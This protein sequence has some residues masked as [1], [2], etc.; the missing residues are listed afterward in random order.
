MPPSATS[1]E[2]QLAEV[3]AFCWVGDGTYEA[4]DWDEAI[5]EAAAASANGSGTIDELLDMPM[6]ASVLEAGLGGV[7]S[8]LRRRRRPQLVSAERIAPERFPRA[9]QRNGEAPVPLI[10]TGRGRNPF[11]DRPAPC[12]RPMAAPCSGW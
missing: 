10:P 3:L 9:A 12:G 6:L 5:E 8:E 2:D 11:P 4:A 1:G 7:R